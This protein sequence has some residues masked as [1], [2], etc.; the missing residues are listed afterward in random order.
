LS[1]MIRKAICKRIHRKIKFIYIYINIINLGTGVLRDAGR[2]LNS[3]KEVKR[4]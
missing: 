2:K 3:A 1:I 4:G